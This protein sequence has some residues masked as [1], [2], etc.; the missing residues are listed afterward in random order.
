MLLQF[1]G[2][3]Y[4]KKSKTLSQGETI[5]LQYRRQVY[6]A[7]Q[8][9]AAVQEAISQVVVLTYRGVPYSKTLQHSC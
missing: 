9:A 8:A 6:I 2:N 4:E 3:T 7:R 1:L 5:Q